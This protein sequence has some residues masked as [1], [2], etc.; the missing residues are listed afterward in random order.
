MC[1]DEDRQTRA[2]A[3]LAFAILNHQFADVLEAG[4]FTQQDHGTLWML[5][6]ANVFT[7]CYAGDL[8]TVRRFIEDDPTVLNAKSP[9]GEGLLY[10]AARSGFRDVVD[11]L[12]FRTPQE[13]A[14]VF[15]EV[16]RSKLLLPPVL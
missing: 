10:I 13:D 12:I 7:Y 4:Q 6:G 1:R 15:L 3:S 2:K 5:D 11:M 16:Q 9:L 8:N 14:S